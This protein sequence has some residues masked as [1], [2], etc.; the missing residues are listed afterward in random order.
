MSVRASARRVRWLRSEPAASLWGFGGISSFAAIAAHASSAHGFPSA[1]S[2]VEL[3]FAATLPFF[4]YR[5][6]V[7]GVQLLDGAVRVI[8][9]FAV[10][11]EIPY[12]DLRGVH[13][14]RVGRWSLVVHLERADGSVTVAFGLRSSRSSLD[15]APRLAAMV[16]EIRRCAGLTETGSEAG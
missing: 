6:Y 4:G 11:E 2:L 5:F 14:A 9:P 3:A 7:S 10:T 15:A 8:N 1:L 16:E 13:V 12:E